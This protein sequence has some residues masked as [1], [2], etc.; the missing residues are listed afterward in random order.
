MALLDD[1]YGKNEYQSTD[2]GW[3][4]YFAYFKR[5][6]KQKKEEDNLWHK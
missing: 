5:L 3:I 1:F 2:A 6:S 4:K